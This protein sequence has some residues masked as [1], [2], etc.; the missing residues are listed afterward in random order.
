MC[1]V[2]L[3]RSAPGVPI[4]NAAELCVCRK[5]RL[6][7]TVHNLITSHVCLVVMLQATM[8]HTRGLCAQCVLVGVLHAGTTVQ[9]AFTIQN[10]GN[11]ALRAIKPRSS[12]TIFDVTCQADSNYSS[13][14]NTTGVWTGSSLSYGY[15]MNVLP[16]GHS[17][18]CQG[19]S[20]ITQE[21]F[22]T[23][24]GPDWVQTVVS[25]NIVPGDTT[26][27]LFMRPVQLASIELQRVGALELR[28]DP[29]NCWHNPYSGK[30]TLPMLDIG[31]GIIQ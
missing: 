13:P 29:Q 4:V 5:V 7:S 27:S 28:L 18:T 26:E 20:T 30:F 24:V 9:L 15:G 11:V 16:V 22:E 3:G 14:T 2:S 10:T 6:D 8:L 21:D 19:S 12:G 17:M 25:S 23:T 1:C 31:V